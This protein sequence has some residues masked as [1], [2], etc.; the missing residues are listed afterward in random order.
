[1]PHRKKSN[2][3]GRPT[4][5][6]DLLLYEST[7]EDQRIYIRVGIVMH[8]ASRWRPQSPPMKKYIEEENKC[9][10]GRAEG[11]KKKK[12]SEKY[13]NEN[14]QSTQFNGIELYN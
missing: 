5:W 3:D 1:M 10:P 7:V 12:K 13:R 8:P 9:R 11:V 6:A 14:Q 4:S 2:R